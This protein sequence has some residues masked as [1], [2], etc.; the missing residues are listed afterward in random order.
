MRK[1]K[2]RRWRRANKRKKERRFLVPGRKK[3][4]RRKERKENVGKE[5]KWPRSFHIIEGYKIINYPN[6]P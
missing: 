1:K 3:R 5:N 6:Y 2:G 4:I